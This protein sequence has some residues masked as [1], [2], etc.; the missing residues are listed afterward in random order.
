MKPVAFNT[1]ILLTTLF[2]ITTFTPVIAQN[3]VPNGSFEQF[4]R[5]PGNYSLEAAEFRAV[6][7]SSATGGTPDQFHACSR[8][9]AGVPYN[10]AGVSDAY[11]GD[12]YAGIFLW[13]SNPKNNYREYLQSKLVEPL[14]K[15][16]TY[17]V[18][19]RYKLSSYSRYSVDRIGL[20]LDDSIVR[21]AHDQVMRRAPTFQIVQDTALTKETGYW[22]KAFFEYRARGGEQ[23]VVIGNFG[24]NQVTKVYHL[25]FGDAPEEMLQVSSYYYIDD[26][27]VAPKFPP[28]GTI[29]LPVLPEF[30][31]EQV[32]LNKTYVLN[33][34]QFE[35]D[36]YKLKKSSF[37]TLEALAVWLMD[38]PGVRVILSGHT[39]DVGGEK[40]NLTLSRNRAGSVAA[41]LISRG[42][43]QSRIEKYG[44][45]EERPV[46]PGITEQART[47]NRRVEAKFIE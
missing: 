42:I 20:L 7:W 11:D 40:Y 33:N 31:P 35:F 2:C 6:D 5:C 1:V 9:G 47:I 14:V 43:A 8:G 18:G 34:I 16:S 37:E 24:D 46:A 38:H 21:E 44:Y 26:V 41:Y 19:F 29:P 17:Q 36:S 13:L 4:S 3:L 23:F 32:E 22:E 10:W 15:D 39:D 30:V 25:Q 27:S 12:G 28:A 45:G